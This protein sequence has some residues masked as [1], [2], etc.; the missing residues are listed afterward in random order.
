MKRILSALTTFVII[1]V[2]VV[3]TSP[4][5]LAAR[6]YG[7]FEFDA[8]DNGTVCITGYNGSAEVL[9]IPETIDGYS[10]TELRALAFKNCSN[11]KEIKIPESVISVGGSTFDDT[12]FYKDEKNWDNGFLYIDNCLIATNPDLI[13]GKITVRP[14]T[15]VIADG[16]FSDCENMTEIELPDGLL[17]IGFS[18]F[19]RCSSLEELI[20]PD[21]VSRI[22]P[23]NIVDDN[24]LYDRNTSLLKRVVIGDGLTEITYDMFSHC[25]N[26]TEVV[27][28]K[29][30]TKIGREAFEYTSIKSLVIPDSVTEIEYRA[31]F[32][33]D[34]LSTVELGSGIQK[35]NESAFGCEN[36]TK[37]SYNGASW[38]WPDVEV[39]SGNDKIIKLVE[40]LQDDAVVELNNDTELEVEPEEKESTPIA[41]VATVLGIVCAGL[42]AYIFIKRKKH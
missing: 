6:T 23:L 26:L 34:F 24:S 3:V 31:F 22:E 35:I 10:V 41:I 13:T 36:I 1:I 4:S 18:A 5:S 12:A 40:Y 9:E 30:V 16:A 32:C 15:R 25:E 28:G 29:N 38:Q 11:I 21:S 7:D 17:T 20:F 2:S 42:L 39:E 27:I 19:H 14:D 33:C 37:V 8:T